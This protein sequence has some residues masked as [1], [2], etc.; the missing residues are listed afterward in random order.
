MKKISCALIGASM[1]LST[2]LIHAD[3]T[4]QYEIPMPGHYYQP[5]YPNLNLNELQKISVQA[6]KKDFYPE[7]ELE[8]LTLDFK[9]ATDLVATNFS[10]DGNVYRAVVED[11]WVY[12]QILV[13]VH[14]MEPISSHTNLEVRLFVVE[15]SSNLNQPAYN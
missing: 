15:Q 7:A 8:Q 2:Q 3:T 13:E 12:K 10:R 4:Y 9:Y 14:A 11:A 6:V 5:L 1:A